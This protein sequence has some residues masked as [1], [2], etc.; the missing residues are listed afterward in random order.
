MKGREL[1]KSVNDTLV[2]DFLNFLYVIIVMSVSHSTVSRSANLKNDSTTF[3][4]VFQKEVGKIHVLW[5]L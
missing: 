2:G 5:P 1:T 3:S 4:L